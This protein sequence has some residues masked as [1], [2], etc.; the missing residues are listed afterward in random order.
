M[1]FRCIEP[2]HPGS[3]ESQVLCF[4]HNMGRHDGGIHIRV[5]FSIIADIGVLFSASHRDHRCG[6]VNAAGDLIDFF[7][8][9]LGREDPQM[10]RL[11]VLCCRGCHTGLKDLFQFFRLYQ[12]VGKLPAGIPF[13]CQF[14]K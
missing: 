7:D 1:Q 8:T 4:H 12:T 11:E 9:L 2:S 5:V 10:D 6:T 14:Q 3:I 13:F